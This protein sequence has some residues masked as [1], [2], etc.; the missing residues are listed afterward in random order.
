[1]PTSAR[2]DCCSAMSCPSKRW[3]A[4]ATRSASRACASSGGGGARRRQAF[5]S[6]TTG[7]PAGLHT[8]P[9]ASCNRTAWARPAPLGQTTYYQH[10]THTSRGEPRAR[11]A[12]VCAWQLPARLLAAIYRA[13]GR[14]PTTRVRWV[15]MMDA[16]HVRSIAQQQA[17]VCMHVPTSSACR[18]LASSCRASLSACAWASIS[19]QPGKQ[20]STQYT[21]NYIMRV[22]RACT[23]AQRSAVHAAGLGRA[24]PWEV[25][26]L[27]SVKSGL[28]PPPRASL[29]GLHPHTW[30]G[31]CYGQLHPLAVMTHAPPP[32]CRALLHCNR[33]HH[34]HHA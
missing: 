5:G 34:H 13:G 23:E 6:A 4:S 7:L 31:C 33:R 29:A 26:H 17:R 25:A 32:L 22:A 14:R 28:R 11:P 12:V 2:N 1:M 19:E 21:V 10:G 18:T 9:P 16:Q 15:V 30:A 20:C 3:A 8:A 27:V 24:R